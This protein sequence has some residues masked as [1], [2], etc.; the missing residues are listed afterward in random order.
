MN[1]I[2]WLDGWRGIY[3]PRDFAESFGNDGRMKSVFNVSDEE[4]KVLEAGP[5]HDHYWDVWDEV[6]QKAEIV[7]PDNNTYRLYQ[8]NDLWLIPAKEQL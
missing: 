5:N 1:Q 4:W 8:D 6:L 2:L 7:F 3:I